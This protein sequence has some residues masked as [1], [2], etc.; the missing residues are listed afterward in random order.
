MHCARN[1]S[2]TTTMFVCVCLQLA[3][4]AGMTFQNMMCGWVYVRP[5]TL[6]NTSH[7]P[8]VQTLK[9]ANVLMFKR[10]PRAVEPMMIMMI[11]VQANCSSSVAEVMNYSESST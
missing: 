10:R 11:N 1:D 9:I 8:S 5:H 3:V 6:R 7:Q 4:Q 2:P